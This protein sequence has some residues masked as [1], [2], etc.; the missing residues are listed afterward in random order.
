MSR[1][2]QTEYCI[3]ASKT[4]LISLTVIYEKLNDG[5]L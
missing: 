5:E 1:N 4:T 3:F 2:S